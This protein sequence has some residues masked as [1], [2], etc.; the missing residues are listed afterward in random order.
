MVPTSGLSAAE[1]GALLAFSTAMAFTPG[2]NT[3]LSAALAANRGLGAALPFVL[4]VPFGWGLLLVAS[5]A[6][7]GALI[8]AQPAAA[9]ALKVLGLVTLLWLAWKL[10]RSDRLGQADGALRVGFWQGVGLQFVNV[11]A[12][13]NALL[14]TAT[15]VTAHADWSYRFVQV[16][17]V[18]MAYALAS[19]LSYALI[20]ATL[21]RW[22]AVGSRLKVFNRCL[23][24]VLAV[25]A[26]WMLRL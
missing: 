3:T 9:Q 4:A 10:A 24:A 11:K 7:L 22:L 2:P 6:G 8:Q 23:A 19:N 25:T 14:I 21:R 16:L 18:L 5:A 20:G 1:F 26:L 13:M 17:P 15:W 12:W